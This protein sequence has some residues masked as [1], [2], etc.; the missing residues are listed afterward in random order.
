LRKGSWRDTEPEHGTNVGTG[1]KFPKK[2]SVPAYPAFACALKARKSTFLKHFHEDCGNLSFLIQAI[3]SSQ[4][5]WFK[6][7]NHRELVLDD[8]TIY[9]FKVCA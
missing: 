5:P 3:F 1:R 8:K 9:A 4:S 2:V 7:K 6:A